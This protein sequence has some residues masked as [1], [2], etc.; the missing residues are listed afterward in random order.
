MKTNDHSRNHY[1]TIQRLNSFPDSFVLKETL[2]TSSSPTQWKR[3]INLSKAWMKGS[4]KLLKG[5][6]EAEITSCSQQKKPP[7]TKSSEIPTISIKK[8][9]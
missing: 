9:A 2:M 1:S 5:S 7:P 3:G 6:T 8:L 4:S